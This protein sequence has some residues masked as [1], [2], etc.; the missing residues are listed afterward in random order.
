MTQAPAI[1]TRVTVRANRIHG[2]LHGI[3]TKIY[4]TYRYDEDLDRPTNALL[5]ESEWHVCVK[6]DRVPKRWPYTGTDLIAPNVSDL[7]E[8]SK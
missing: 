4:P 2:V 1:G 6:V 3:V 8:L 7:K 5:P